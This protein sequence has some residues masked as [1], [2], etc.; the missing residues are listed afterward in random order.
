ML[1]VARVFTPSATVTVTMVLLSSL[2]C[3]TRYCPLLGGTVLNCAVFSLCVQVFYVW[4]DAP[5]GYLSITANYTDEWRQWW[6]SPKDVELVQ[7]MGKDNVPFH[8][9]R[10]PPALPLESRLRSSV[11]RRS[12]LLA[13]RDRR[14]READAQDLMRHHCHYATTVPTLFVTLYK[15]GWYCGDILNIPTLYRL[16]CH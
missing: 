11:D 1:D 9:V 5:I 13:P 6:Q 16:P 7:F 4:F 15:E 14:G 8:T 12:S 2:Y 3:T 10:T